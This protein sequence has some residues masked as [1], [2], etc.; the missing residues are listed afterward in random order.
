MVR[1][2]PK[3][4]IEADPVGAAV[5]ASLLFAAGIAQRRLAG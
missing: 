4:K 1:A 2:H 3:N 5:K